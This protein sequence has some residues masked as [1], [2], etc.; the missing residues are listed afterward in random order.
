MDPACKPEN[1]KLSAGADHYLI[2]DT[3]IVLH[4]TDFLEHSAITDVIILSTVYQ[5][6]QHKNSSVFLRLKNLLRNE[7]KRFYY[8]SN[9][10]HKV[11]VVPVQHASLKCASASLVWAIHK[12]LP[13]C[14]QRA[15]R[16]SKLL[17][18]L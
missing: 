18:C 3:N 10:H 9:E 13:Q 11:C 8:F 4:Q 17:M 6:V 7:S 12:S 2:V 15:D 1:A 14:T 16:G 5:E